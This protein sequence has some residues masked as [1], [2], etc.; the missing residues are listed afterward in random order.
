MPSRIAERAREDAASGGDRPP[1]PGVV[2]RVAAV[3]LRIVE[4][5]DQDDGL[6][7]AAALAFT[8]LLSLVP[9]FTVGLALLAGFPTFEPYR[10]QLMQLVLDQMILSADLEV[11][12]LF[13][14][15]IDNA[16]ELGAGG[17]I[18]LAISAVLLLSSIRTA[19]NR[20]WRG[21]PRPFVHDIPVYW[22][23]ITLGPLLFGAA[24]SLSGTAAAM[25]Q[26]WFGAAAKDALGALGGLA[27]PVLEIVGFAM[28]Y[29]VMPNVR[30]RLGHALAGAALATVLFE[31]MKRLFGLYIGSVSYSAVYGVL[32]TVPVLFVWI[33]LCWVLTL[34]GAEL[35][36]VLGEGPMHAPAES[37]E[38]GEPSRAPARAER[39]GTALSIL[40]ALEAARADGQMPSIF[41]TPLAD[42]ADVLERLLRARFVARTMDDRAIL[43]RDLAQTDLHSLCAALDVAA[44][45]RDE[46]QAREPW[47]D[48]VAGVLGGLD[49]AARGALDAPLARVIE[50][51]RAK[52]EAAE[53]ARG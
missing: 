23:A 50:A 14:E 42:D 52:A 17:V 5:F 53:Q 33:Y 1:D 36:A 47:T 29:R 24:L 8:S 12:R 15:F 4:R 6:E 11:R 7:S 31:L 18:G 38:A 48:A 25:A 22:M 10:E 43:A 27:P 19:L 9:L 46:A 26:G 21:L 44:P 28:L 41:A 34:I 37:G 16:A 32:A 40:A 2:G 35:V 3:V 30:V 20:V 49:A 13:D 45:A 51:H 39:L